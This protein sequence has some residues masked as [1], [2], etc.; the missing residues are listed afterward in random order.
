MCTEETLLKGAQNYANVLTDLSSTLLTISTTPDA[1]TSKNTLSS[2]FVPS[3]DMQS[4]VL[5]LTPASNVAQRHSFLSPTNEDY[6]LIVTLDSSLALPS[7][8]CFIY[9]NNLQ[10]S[11]LPYNSDSNYSYINMPY[12]AD[13]FDTHL[14]CTGL[15]HQFSELF[16]KLHNDFPISHNLSPLTASYTPNNLPRANLFK[17]V[18]NDYITEEL[19]K[20]RYLGPYSHDQ[21]FAMIGHFR[22][23]PLQVV[24]KKGVDSSPD[25]FRVCQHLSYSESMGHSV[26]N[27]IDSD[28]YPTKWGMAAEFAEIVC[29]FPHTLSLSLVSFQMLFAQSSQGLHD[30]HDVLRLKARTVNTY[31]FSALSLS[32]SLISPMSQ[33]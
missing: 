5:C 22:S 29:H 24:V 7:P 14:A 18:C 12:L 6:F 11:P 26:N 2:T 28:S 13:G 15:M 23:S 31:L 17:Q 8:P 25:K 16:Y 20:G 3:V 9:N 33:I 10:H 1:P 4:T 32:L 27:E 21:L 19:I 30:T